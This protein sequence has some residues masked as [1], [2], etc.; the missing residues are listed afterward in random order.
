VVSSVNATLNQEFGF[1]EVPIELEY[2]VL[3]KKFGL[4]VIGGFSTFFLDNNKV[5]TTLNGDKALLGEAKN[6]NDTSYSANFGLGLNY[7]LSEKIKFNLEPTFKYQFNTFR[8]TSGD[9]QPY[10]IGIYTGLS[11]KF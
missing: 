8:D 10:F 7:N 9:F 6:I 2:A 4:N 5:Y 3:N 1:I 11:Y